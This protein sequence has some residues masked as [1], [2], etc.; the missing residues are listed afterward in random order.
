MAQLYPPILPPDNEHLAGL[1]LPPKMPGLD[2]GTR[3][4]KTPAGAA[5]PNPFLRYEF[6]GGNKVNEIEFDVDTILFSYHPDETLASLNC[7]T[8]FAHMVAAR[9][10]T[11]N[12]WF[13]SGTVGVSLPHRSSDPQVPLPRYRAMVTWR[14]QGHAIT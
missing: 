6:G 3:L 8:A 1:Y 2:M 10:E 13:V 9:G 14:V 7:R 12:G 11:V 5:L 4:P